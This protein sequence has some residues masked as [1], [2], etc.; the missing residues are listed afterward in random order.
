MMTTTASAARADGMTVADF[1]A[2]SHVN[3]KFLAAIGGA[4]DGVRTMNV[5]LEV[6]RKQQK[7]FCI[8][9]DLGLVPE[10]TREIAERYLRTHP[11]DAAKPSGLYALVVIYAYADAFPCR[12][13]R[14]RSE[15]P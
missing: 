12:Q 8:P 5:Y 13:A 15:R 1:L 7:S 3:P 6:T 4:A 14:H 10:Q 9:P 11:D 2:E